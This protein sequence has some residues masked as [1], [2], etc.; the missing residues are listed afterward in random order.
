MDLV[1]VLIEASVETRESDF[2]LSL[3]NAALDAYYSDLFRRYLP[4]EP[5]Q[6]LARVALNF[7]LQQLATRSRADREHER[8]L[9]IGSFDAADLAAG[10]LQ[11]MPQTIV[12]WMPGF[13]A[14]TVA[15]TSEVVDRIR[16][17][18][19]ED[20]MPQDLT[21]SSTDW[22]ERALVAPL[23]SYGLICVFSDRNIRH[24]ADHIASLRRLLN[25]R[26]RVVVFEALT[27]G[28][29]PTD[30]ANPD[31]VG[32]YFMTGPGLT[33]TMSIA[34]LPALS[35]PDFAGTEAAA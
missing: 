8:F 11:A 22:R 30:F 19:P 13:T 5:G 12:E 2:A 3:G 25:A 27:G 7:M 23:A 34:V 32:R 31:F 20:G 10:L 6:A 9:Q 33:R 29:R 21:I 17:L 14:V 4:E 26:G 15:E 24:L 1:D 35:G 28:R 16:P 18:L